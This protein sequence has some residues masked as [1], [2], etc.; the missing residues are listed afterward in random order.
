MK[1]IEKPIIKRVTCENCGCIFQP[2]YRNLRRRGGSYYK[3]SCFC[4]YCGK[5]NNVKFGKNQSGENQSI[6][7]AMSQVVAYAEKTSKALESC[8]DVMRGG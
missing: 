4:P 2:K 3:D 7:K 6:D 1:I 5:R 8:F